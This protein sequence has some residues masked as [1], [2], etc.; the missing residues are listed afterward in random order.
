[1]PFF[2]HKRPYD[3]KRMNLE[4]VKIVWN[5]SKHRLPQ[6]NKRK[7]SKLRTRN[8]YFICGAGLLAAVGTSFSS[9][10]TDGGGGSCTLSYRVIGLKREFSSTIS[11]SGSSPRGEPVRDHGRAVHRDRD[12]FAPGDETRRRLGAHHELGGYRMHWSFAGRR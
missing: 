11:G 6:Q 5:L 2:I 10:S 9:T 4:D 7:R 8:I 1:M 12:H 3:Q